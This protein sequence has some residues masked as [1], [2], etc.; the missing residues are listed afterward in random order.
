MRN[1]KSYAKIF[2]VL[3]V[4][5]ALLSCTANN[6]SG[7]TGGVTFTDSLGNEITVNNPERV[8][9]LFGSYTEV[10]QLA[11]GKVIATTDD[12]VNERKL[13]LGKDVEIIG[14]VKEPNLEKI[15]DLNAD[16]VILSSDITAQVQVAETLKKAGINCAFF[17]AEHFSDYL[18]MLNIFT[19]ITGRKDLYKK[20]GLD[21]KTKIDAVVAKT[22]EIKSGPSV[23]Y[24]RAYSTGIKTKGEDDMVGAM[25][26][27]LKAQNIVSKYPSL[28]ENLNIEQII[29][30]NPDCIFI[31]VMGSEDEAEAEIDKIILSNEALKDVSA[32]KNGRCY[33]LDK[34]HFH[35]KPNAR[36]AES[37]EILYNDLY[38]DKQ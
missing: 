32:I 19:D 38:E 8:I 28:L 30:A 6:T 3:T 27:D 25:F 36:W 35:Y 18:S 34:E 11:G 9:S 31:S 22:D 13:D 33:I 15:I 2:I 37:Y 17:K 16:F 21:I 10:W 12:A 26:K 5:S 7:D 14:T 29:L 23:L 1:V 24:M 4:L 20:N